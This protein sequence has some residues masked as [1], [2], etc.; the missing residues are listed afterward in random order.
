MRDQ[1]EAG[2]ALAERLMERRCMIVCG[3]KGMQESPTGFTRRVLQDAT[4]KFADADLASMHHIGILDLTKFGR[5]SMPDIEAC[6]VWAT[7]L[8]NL[9]PERSSQLK[10]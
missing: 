10:V 9:N 2:L 7:R 1:I 8:L 6:S 3:D 5:L 4:A